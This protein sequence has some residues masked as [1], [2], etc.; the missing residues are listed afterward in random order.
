MD[1]AFE[2]T[3]DLE[4]IRKIVTHEKIWPHVSD[5]GAGHP[6][7]YQ[8]VNHP[9]IWYVT[10]LSNGQLM[11][12]WIFTPENSICFGVH[13]CLLPQAWGSF[14]H[15]AARAMAQWVWEHTPCKRIVTTVPTYN[16]LA[17][18]FAKGA[19]MEQYGLNPRSYQ[20]NGKLYDQI[21]LGISR[22]EEIPCL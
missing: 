20:K 11:G 19:G 10:V 6:E 4:L 18:A 3:T 16:R 9:A 5:D 17:L 1:I 8:P 2:R 12:A 13:T 22:P 14:A 7:D 15:C 21:L